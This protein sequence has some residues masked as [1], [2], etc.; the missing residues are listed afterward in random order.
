MSYLS[1]VSVLH[2]LQTSYGSVLLICFTYCIYVLHKMSYLFVLHTV[3][4][5]YTNVLLICFTYCI[6]V[7]HECL[8]Y[9][10]YIMSYTNVLLL[11]VLNKRGANF[12]SRTF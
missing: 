10:F 12:N 8:T 2:T 6:Y 5:S 11:Q 4:M 3:S 1:Y 9:L 7:L